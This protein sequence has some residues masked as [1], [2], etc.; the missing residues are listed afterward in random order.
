MSSMLK[1]QRIRIAEAKE[2]KS[3][4]SCLL[5]YVMDFH[6]ELAEHNSGSIEKWNGQG[7]KKEFPELG[8]KQNKTLQGS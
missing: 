2:E 1:F 6:E 8:M 3:R 5:N 4:T 7:P